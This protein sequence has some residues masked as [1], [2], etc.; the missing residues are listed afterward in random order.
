MMKVELGIGALSLPAAFSTLGLIP[1]ILILTCVAVITTWSNYMIG[2]FKLKHPEVYSLGD[3]GFILFG[4]IGRE[5]FTVVFQLCMSF[6]LY[7]IC[8]SDVLIKKQVFVFAASSAFVTVSTALNAITSHG[9]CTAIF[10]AVAAI[11][12]FPLASI[13]RL[14]DQSWLAWG[15]LGSIMASSK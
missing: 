2:C 9:A 7:G 12:A 8:A 3:V 13:P 14:K 5:V 15:G 1:G 6:F 11:I 4:R 10:I